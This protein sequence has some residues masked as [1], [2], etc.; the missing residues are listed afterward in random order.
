MNDLLH[1]I[2]VRDLDGKLHGE[3]EFILLDVREKWE[4]SYAHLTDRRVHHLPMSIISQDLLEAFPAELRSPATDIVVICHHGVRS[5]NVATWMMQ[6]G[7]TKVSSLAGGIDAFA[8]EIDPSVG[9]Y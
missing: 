6:N 2:S 1:E 9:M 3:D 5:A 8:V 4:L 7:W